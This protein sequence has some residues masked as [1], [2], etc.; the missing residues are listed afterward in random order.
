MIFTIGHSSRPWADFISLLVAHSIDLVVDVRSFPG[1]RHCPWF[2]REQLAMALPP[3]GI[4]YVHLPRLGGRR[5]PAPQGLPRNGW[6]NHPSFQAY[7]DYASS[8]PE[9]LIGL[10][11]L[12]DLGHGDLDAP[13][14]LRLA[15]MCA[16]AQWWRCHRRILA[17]WLVANN[18]SVGHIMSK[19]R[20]E[21]HVLSEGAELAGSSQGLNLVLYPSQEPE[22][23]R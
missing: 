6:W 3:F 12:L 22:N 9:F 18:H 21:A 13:S 4:D 17:D 23:E 8:D 11:E 2:G 7:A 10:E 1:S 20:I 19:T 16:E 15:I 5:R 14:G